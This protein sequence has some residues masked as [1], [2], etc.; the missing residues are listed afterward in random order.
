MIMVAVVGVPAEAIMECQILKNGGGGLGVL[1]PARLI[2]LVSG[3][4]ACRQT[5]PSLYGEHRSI[6]I[7]GMK[8]LRLRLRD[9]LKT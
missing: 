5:N 3:G 1:F 7:V 2:R 8:R 4:I 9:S 6:T